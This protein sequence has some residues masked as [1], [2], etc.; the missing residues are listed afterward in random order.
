MEILELGE[1]YSEDFFV[2]TIFI[3]RKNFTALPGHQ[4]LNLW[5]TVNCS[6]IWATLHHTRLQVV[7]ITYLTLALI[8][9]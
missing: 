5:F 6:T 1:I 8:L 9:T 3:K 2:F 7:A 4:T